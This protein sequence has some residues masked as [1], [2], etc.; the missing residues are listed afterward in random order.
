MSLAQYFV[1]RNIP[2]NKFLNDADQM[3]DWDGFE[4]LINHY[5]V[6]K[7]GGRPPYPV[8]LMLKM[9]LLQS[10]YGLSDEQT[11]FQ[12]K[13]RLTFRKFLNLGIEDNVP[14]ATTLEN[15]RHKLVA[16]NLSTYLVKYFDECCVDNGLIKKEGSLIDATFI[17]ANSKPHRDEELK[18]DIDAEFGYKGYG[19][20]ATVNV[21][22]KSKLIRKTVSAPNNVQESLEFVRVLTGEEVEVY[23]DK[24]YDRHCVR[25]ILKKRKIRDRVMYQARRSKKGLPAKVLKWQREAINRYS[26]KTRARVEHI[27][28]FW[29]YVF[30]SARARYRGL[31]R[32][33]GQM[34][35]LT[36]AYNL[37]RM[38]FL[39]KQTPDF[40]W[41][42]SV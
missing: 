28:A 3:I 9:H 40:V 24:G 32:V 27:F 42:N 36:L 15:F 29:K 19:Y 21:D 37:K 12:C 10:W 7:K 4:K 26:A 33:N 16:S 17:K 11:E 2:E 18:S 5:I 38:V 14:D 34:Q 20:K 41:V 23:A 31:E 6:Y 25:D 35:S 8:I 39:R 13:D 30:K 1:D 22:K